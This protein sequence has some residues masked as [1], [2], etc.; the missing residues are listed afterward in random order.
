MCVCVCVRA[1]VCVCVCVTKVGVVLRA[2]MCCGRV[3]C[4]VSRTQNIQMHTRAHTTPTFTHTNKKPDIYQSFFFTFGCD[5][6]DI[7]GTMKSHSTHKFT[8]IRRRYTMWAF[9]AC[10]NEDFII[11]QPR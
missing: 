4:G 11:I 2:C 5:Q 10:V 8:Y 6:L 7:F 3:C 1:L 9:V